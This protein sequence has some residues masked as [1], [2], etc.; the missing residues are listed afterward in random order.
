L[1]S[2]TPDYIAGSDP[3]GRLAKVTRAVQAAREVGVSWADPTD[4]TD[5]NLNLVSQLLATYDSGTDRYHPTSL[6]SHDLAILALT[7][8]SQS[9]YPEAVT[10]IE[11]DQKGNGGWGWAWDASTPD[12]DATAQSMQALTAAGGPGSPNVFDNAAAF[13][14]D[15]Q[16]ADGGFP[17][18]A[19]R[20]ETNCNSTA[21][22]VQG[23]LAIGRYR[24]APL[25]LST[26]KGGLFSSWDALLAF[27]QQTG[28]FSFT[29]SSPGSAMLAT[30][31]A[32]PALV[33]GYYP[34][35]EPRSEVD[36]TVTGQVSSRLTCGHGLQVVA[37]YTGDDD[38]D[39][40]A[41]LRY[42]V[43]ADPT[44]NEVLSMHKGGLAYLHLLDLEVGTEYEL[45]VTYHDLDEITGDNPQIIAVQTGRSCVPLVM[46]DFS[47]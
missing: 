22:A 5:E 42:H 18:L 10:A 32:I 41:R 34:A 39:G 6:Y 47:G 43:V 38:N 28:S 35:Y 24:D 36:G 44:W 7:E 37:P 26:G 15:L 25:L 3:A 40:C 45:E 27:Q 30:L 14:E 20:P 31:D 19:T 12:A 21:L 17:D 4:F 11:N 16:F 33:S 29:S 46:R 8:V 9:I 1:E 2:T 13:L 23:L